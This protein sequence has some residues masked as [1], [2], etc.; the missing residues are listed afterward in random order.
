[1]CADR[2]CDYI[3]SFPV[4]CLVGLLFPGAGCV[5]IERGVYVCVY[6]DI[7]IR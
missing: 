4:K 2:V 6:I 5:Q 7:F 3:S 1:M